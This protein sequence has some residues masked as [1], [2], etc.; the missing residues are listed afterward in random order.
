M[1]RY[2][3]IKELL[4]SAAVGGVHG[5]QLKAATSHGLS[6]PP[7]PPVVVPLYIYWLSIL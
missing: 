1:M 7:P 5:K 2:G 6:P 3:S 4:T